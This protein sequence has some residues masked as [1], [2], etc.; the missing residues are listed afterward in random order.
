MLRVPLVTVRFDGSYLHKPRWAKSTRFVPIAADVRVA[1]SPEEV[2]K[3]SVEEIHKRIVDNLT[4]DDYAYQLAKGIAVD[5][6]D[7]CEGLEGVLYKCPNCGQEFAMTAH[8]NTL[9]CAKCGAE[10]TQDKYGSLSGGRFDKVTDWYIWQTEVV[11]NDLLSG[12]Y[13]FSKQYVCEKLVG[14]KYVTVGDATITHDESGLTATFGENKLFYKRDEFYT[15][16]FNNDYVFLPAKE[17]VYRF[18]RTGELGANCKLN[19]AIE[20][21]SML[22]EQNK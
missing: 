3:L 19:I 6:P 12:N 21:Q 8:G 2:G 14:K 22:D 18:K 17:A 20:Q 15:L 7:L 10:F 16:S 1:V 13:C 4:Y 9:T 5:V 11:R